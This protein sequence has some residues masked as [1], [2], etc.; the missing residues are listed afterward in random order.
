[1]R[2]T[3]GQSVDGRAL[4]W[5]GWG[6]SGGRGIGLLAICLWNLV[7]YMNSV[8]AAQDKTLGEIR[9]ELLGKEVIVTGSKTS[10]IGGNRPQEVLIEW[11]MAAKDEQGSYKERKDEGLNAYA[12]Y[13]LKGQRGIVIAIEL[14]ESV[15]NRGKRGA[16]LDILGEKVS[17]DAASKPYFDLVVRLR[18]GRLLMT[19]G[20]YVTIGDRLRFVGDIDQQKNEI[21][22]NINMLIGRTIYK[23]G[24]STVYPQ[25]IVMD[26]ATDSSMRNIYKQKIFQI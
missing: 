11:R 23:I 5:G 10:G 12:P 18:T 14:A 9:R 19:R 8:E 17:D 7:I 25:D 20:N 6:W 26:E 3:V 24:Y 1:M 2:E 15:L 21:T 16:S 13:A 4:G 22:K